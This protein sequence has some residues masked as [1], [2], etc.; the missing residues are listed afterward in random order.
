M[1]ADLSQEAM[2]ARGKCQFPLCWNKLLGHKSLFS[3]SM[4]FWDKGEIKGS[5]TL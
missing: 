2:E 5:A 4:S 1:T 3:N